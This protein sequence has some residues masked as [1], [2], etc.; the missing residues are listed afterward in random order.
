MK[1][2]VY[3]FWIS[4]SLFRSFC[5]N[6]TLY[7]CFLNSRLNVSTSFSACM[8]KFLSSSS[9]NNLFSFSFSFRPGGKAY[10]YRLSSSS[11]VKKQKWLS[12]RAAA[13]GK[14]QKNF[15]E[16]H[17][18]ILKG[19]ILYITITNDSSVLSYACWTI[20]TSEFSFLAALILRGTVCNHFPIYLNFKLFFGGCYFQSFRPAFFT[21]LLNKL[22]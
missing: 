13:E 14:V 21:D 4:N 10:Q 8:W 9:A 5:S 2:V 15:A 18:R 11:S 3:I 12:P 20:I 17:P 6:F 7:F 1:F 19:R 22:F 16:W